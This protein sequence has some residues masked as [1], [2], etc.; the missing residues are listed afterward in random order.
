[1]LQGKQLL[2]VQCD[3]QGRRL[4]GHGLILRPWKR[5]VKELNMLSNENSHQVS[6]E[7]RGRR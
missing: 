2:E 4:Y 5:R 7:K 1:M 6:A 3:S